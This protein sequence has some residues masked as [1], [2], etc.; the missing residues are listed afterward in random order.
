MAR[1]TPPLIAALVAVAWASGVAGVGIDVT[2]DPALDMI[3]QQ[4]IAVQSYTP[5][6][7]G[8]SV[9][10]L[11]LYDTG[12]SVIS[13]SWYGNQ[14]FPQPHLNPGGAGGQGVNGSVVGDVSQ[15]GAILAGGLQ[16]FSLNFDPDTFEFSGGIVTPAD[17]AVDGIQAFVGT[18]TGSPNLP[19]LTG[20]PIH[21]PSA[22][23]PGGSA[24]RI[25]MTGIDFGTSLGLGFPLAFPALE[26]VAPGSTVASRPG[27]TQPASIPLTPFGTGNRGTEGT[28]ITVAPNPTFADVTL[29]HAPPVGGVNTVVASRLLFD[30]GAQVSLI[31]GSLAA[32]LG[33]DPDRPDTTIRVQGASGVPIALDGYTID[34]IE[35]AA[36]IDGAEADDLV[37]FGAVPVFVYDLG[38]TGLDGI[39]GMNLFN[40]ADEMVVDLVN[41]VLQVSF[42][43][44][45][46]EG[47]SGSLD[48]LAVLFGG[49]SSPA[50]T[51][52]LVPAFGLG[53]MM[54]VP[55]PGGL[56]MLLAG[57]ALGIGRF[58][59]RS[60][61]RRR[62]GDRV[63]A[64]SVASARLAD[65]GG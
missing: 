7:G 55:E 12:A 63:L 53:S 32:A 47:T 15:P 64:R 9:I 46:A 38:I 17:R 28:S 1:R 29:R 57:A 43:E 37:R 16:D 19:S 18:E 27:S 10:D 34:A 51:G 65:R 50:F 6:A 13:F 56:A 52:Q 23:F 62:A 2:L 39:L 41:D 24:A 11:A 8:Q 58:G 49:Y 25:T 42:F 21:A 3:G 20:T 60:H 45:G 22:A 35:L 26:L 54:V 30:T 59:R 4:V 14:Y 40:S 33:L 44:E 36:A 61:G 5:A 48:Q 31:S